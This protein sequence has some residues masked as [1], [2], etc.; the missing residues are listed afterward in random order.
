MSFPV[1]PQAG[2]ATSR[3][4]MQAFYTTTDRTLACTQTDLFM[5]IKPIKPTWGCKHPD[6]DPFHRGLGKHSALRRTVLLQPGP[7][8]RVRLQLAAWQEFQH[9]T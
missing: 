2:E 9:G 1:P 8:F 6:L 7:V 5:K 3:E 4:S